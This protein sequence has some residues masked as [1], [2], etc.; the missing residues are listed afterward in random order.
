MPPY[1]FLAQK[2]YSATP[3]YSKKRYKRSYRAPM[4]KNMSFKRAVKK[5]VGAEVK[6]T[7]LSV[8]PIQLPSVTGSFVHL[9]GIGKGTGRSARIGDWIAPQALYGSIVI[10]GDSAA[11]VETNE[12]KIGCLRW[13][14]DVDIAGPPSAA[15]I[16]DDVASPL[17]PYEFGST[18][19]FDILY[20][21][22]D[23]L[24]TFPGN[25]Q[26]QKVYTF[27]INL[28]NGPKVYYD[29]DVAA[30]MHLYFFGLSNI[31]TAA[32]PP[33]YFFTLTVKYTDS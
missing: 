28:S 4:Y 6:F 2:S 11:A 16:F 1:K 5:V 27:S 8:G 14:N 18:R 26:H 12:Y 7:T 22:P 15:L 13:R 23:I 19:S 9:T 25:S 3:R 33:N 31:D 10:E 17:G 29:D 30:K 24:S 21:R 32:N 20:A